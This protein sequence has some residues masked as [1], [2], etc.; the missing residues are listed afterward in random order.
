MTPDETKKLHRYARFKAFTLQTTLHDQDDLAQEALVHVLTTS[1]P[2]H[3]RDVAAVRGMLSVRRSELQQRYG[4]RGYKALL[5]A[6]RARQQ[7]AHTLGREPRTAEILDAAGLSW[8]DWAQTLAPTFVPTDEV[9][10]AS[11]ADVLNEVL[12]EETKH[13]LRRAV[14]DLPKPQRIAAEDALY[15]GEETGG[16]HSTDLKK[17][18][19][20]L[21]ERLCREP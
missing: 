16:R 19:Q 3:Q 6:A 18:V 2:A 1:P 13:E 14:N 20:S 17:A 21:R 5:A 4:A 10:V 7:L 12:Q 11:D 9:P 15:R 8:D